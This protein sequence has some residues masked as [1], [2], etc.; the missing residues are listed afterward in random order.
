MRAITDKK[1]HICE[2]LCLL[3]RKYRS[4]APGESVT[5]LKTKTITVG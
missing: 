1:P 5:S 3:S 4:E 2:G